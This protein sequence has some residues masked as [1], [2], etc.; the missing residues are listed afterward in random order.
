MPEEDVLNAASLEGFPIIGFSQKYDSVVS[1][2]SDL[3]FLGVNNDGVVGKLDI[4]LYTNFNISVSDLNFGQSAQLVS[5]EIVLAISNTNFMGNSQSSLTYS[6]YVMDSVMNYKRAYYTNNTKLHSTNLITV[7]T[8]SFTT[9]AGKTAIRIPMNSTFADQLLHNTPALVNNDYLQNA[10]RGF[11]I[12][13]SA[14]DEGIIYQCDLSDDISGLYLNYRKTAADT[15]S[16]FRFTFNGPFAA[17]FNTVK[18]TPVSDLAGQFA[19][20]TALGA[21]KIYLRGMGAAKAKIYV[22]WLKNYGDT[23]KVAVNRAQLFFY[24]DETF[25]NSLRSTSNLSYITPPKLCLYALDSLG[26]ETTLLDLKNI[27]Y[28]SRFDGAYDSQNKRYAFN[29]PLHAQAIL[30]GKIKNYGFALVMTDSDPLYSAFRDL[31]QQSCILQGAS[32]AK[33]PTFRL[34]YIRLK[35]E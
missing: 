21:Q 20:D 8:S 13:T 32:A 28:V 24:L 15:V 5:S 3:K 34:D 16:Q 27:N 2:N 30:R 1:L 18:F 33:K 9:Y 29:I 31:N 17:R 11:Y 14:N 4:G 19:G 10:Y 7:S 22:P 35:G 6:V 23:F 26:R 12:K 25:L